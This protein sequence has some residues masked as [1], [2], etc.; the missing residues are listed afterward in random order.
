MNDK[1]VNSITVTIVVALISITVFILPAPLAKACNMF[2][3][4]FISI[5]SGIDRDTAQKFE[6]FLSTKYPDISYEANPAGYEG[7][8]D[9]CFD[10]SNLPEEQQAAFRKESRQILQKSKLVQISEQENCPKKL[11]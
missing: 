3:V 11:E 4:S 5:G 10:L 1:F 2:V 7:E 8:R 6:N 9:Y